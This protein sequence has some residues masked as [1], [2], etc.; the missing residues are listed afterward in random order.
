MNN[1]R[2][3]VWWLFPVMVLL[4]ACK[5]TPPLTPHVFE[6]DNP[7]APLIIGLS[8]S[9]ASLAEYISDPY[10]SEGEHAGLQIIT[11]NDQ[12]LL[13]QLAG[14]ELDAAIVY[15][16][17]DGIFFQSTP[18]AMDGI[19]ICT[20]PE[21]RL[22]GIGLQTLQTLYSGIVRNWSM[23]DQSNLPVT[24][25]GREEG[26]GART[27]FD[28]LVMDGS[29]LSPEML[30]AVNESDMIQQVKEVPGALGYVMIASLQDLSAL[31]VNGIKPTP[32]TVTDES[33]PLTVPIFL[34]T[35]AEPSGDLELLGSILL[36]E[37]WQA[38]IG[39]KYGRLR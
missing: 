15:Q 31:P 25:F 5:E 32:E 26:S 2:L 27:L 12:T 9:A 3:L 18:I 8:D 38:S 21:I 6:I 30:I 23:F 11:G 28:A 19:A 39:E 10:P 22:E 36:S 16:Q 14:G 13:D 24:L 33:Y 1:Q 34:V 29:K 17:P 4:A 7:I 37:E 35:V 20:Q